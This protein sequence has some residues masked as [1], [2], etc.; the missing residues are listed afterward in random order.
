MAAVEIGVLPST[1]SFEAVVVG[2]QGSHF[3]SASAEAVDTVAI[4]AAAVVVDSL[5]SLVALAP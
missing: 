4:V 2:P 3:H 1:G 5:H